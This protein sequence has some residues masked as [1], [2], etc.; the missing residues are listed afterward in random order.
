MHSV[1][2]ESKSW[3][4]DKRNDEKI[5]DKK[6]RSQDEMKHSIYETFRFKLKSFSILFK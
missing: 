6:K 3:R 4:A 1:D 2:H 5:F